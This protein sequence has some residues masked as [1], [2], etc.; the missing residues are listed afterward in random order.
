MVLTI[1]ES[2]TEKRQSNT[3]VLN[4]VIKTLPVAPRISKIDLT[5][6]F[7][8]RLNIGRKRFRIAKVQYRNGFL[9]EE[10]KG[11]ILSCNEAARKICDKL[12]A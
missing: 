1:K 2:M 7:A 11:G 6:C 9:V 5:D 4:Y 12:E 3:D 8:I 10:V